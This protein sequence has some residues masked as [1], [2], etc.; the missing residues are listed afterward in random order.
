MK[1]AYESTL[2]EAVASHVRLWELSPLARRWKLQGI[3][4]VPFLVFTIHLIMY[5]GWM[6]RIVFTVL[7]CAILI[8]FYLYYYKKAVVSRTRKM[9]TEYIGTNEPVPCE[10]E[11]NEEGLVFRRQ[12]TEVKFQWSAIGTVSI[13]ERGIEVLVANHGGIAVLPRRIFK[14]NEMNEWFEFASSRIPARSNGEE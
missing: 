11:F 4:L 3:L 2:E 9:L 6:E 12:G 5:E 8:P 13:V 14:G 1:I 7:G 10:Y